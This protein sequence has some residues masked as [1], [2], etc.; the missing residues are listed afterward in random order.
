MGLIDCASGNSL[1]RGY[2][3]YKEKKVKTFVSTTDTTFRGIVGGSHGE[4]YSVTIDIEHPRKSSCNCPFADGKR[5]VCKHQIAV[6]FSAFPKEADRIYR[7]A[8]E[9]EKEEAR[10][11][12]EIEDRLKSCIHKMKKS[13]LEEVLLQILYDGPEWQYDHFVRDYVDVDDLYD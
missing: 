7:E 3:Y 11:E 2:D 8:I 4:S 9:Y 12:E 1:W 13:E 6:Y 10:R 5:I